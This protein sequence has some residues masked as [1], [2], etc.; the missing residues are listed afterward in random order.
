MMGQKL[1]AT[2]ASGWV[3]N[4]KPPLK[5]Q[6]KRLKE[7]IKGGGKAKSKERATKETQNERK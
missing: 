7:E 2:E 1:E 5:M 6:K 3:H 4:H